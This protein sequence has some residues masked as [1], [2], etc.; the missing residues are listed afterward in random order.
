[1][2]TK[3]NDYLI[4]YDRYVNLRTLDFSDAYEISVRETD[5][6]Y[7]HIAVVPLNKNYYQHETQIL[8]FRSW[9]I[10]NYP[11][12]NWPYTDTGIEIQSA[13]KIEAKLWNILPQV[14]LLNRWTKHSAKGS[15]TLLPPEFRM[16]YF[17]RNN[18]VEFMDAIVEQAKYYHCSN[19]DDEGDA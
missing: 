18:V 11:N 2:P 14:K 13:A 17:E 8:N 6:G 9:V 3:S 5:N 7:L 1:M 19:L 16:T 10:R 12:S 4:K 15:L